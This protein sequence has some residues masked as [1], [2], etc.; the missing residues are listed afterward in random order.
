[1]E[2]EIE[3]LKSI[4]Q[5]DIIRI[6]LQNENTLLEILIYPLDD[7]E[8]NKKKNLRLN[9]LTYFSANVFEILKYF[10]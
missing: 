7:E 9:L 6:E 2:E 4:Y 3:I 10:L 1:M 5:D 8:N